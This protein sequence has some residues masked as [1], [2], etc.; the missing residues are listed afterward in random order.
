MFCLTGISCGFQTGTAYDQLEVISSDGI[1]FFKKGADPYTGLVYR[2]S[3]SFRLEE[4]TVDVGLQSGIADTFYSNGQLKSRKFYRD[5]E[6][7]GL[8]EYFF[9]SGLRMASLNYSAGK[10]SGNQYKY[11]PSGILEEITFYEKGILKGENIFYYEDGKIRQRIQ[12]NQLGQRSG[13]WTKFY[14]NGKLKESIEFQEGKLIPPVLRY[15]VLGK[16]IP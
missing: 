7:N 3:L 9:E 15:D 2:D 8:V 4:F 11:Y 14:S 12:F 6:L 1:T 5:G 16:R 13:T 10:K